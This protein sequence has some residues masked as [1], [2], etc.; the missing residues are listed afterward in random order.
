MRCVNTSV[1]GSFRDPSGFLFFR[2]GNLYRQINNFYKDHYTFLNTSGLYHTLIQKKLLIP[3]S[4]VDLPP[5]KPDIAFKIIQPTRIPFISYPYEWCFSQLKQAA[6][7]TL[8]IQKISLD[9][10]MILKDAS[11]YNI[12]FFEGKPIFIDTLSFERYEPGKPWIAYRQFCKHFIAPLA[13]M[14]YKDIRLGELLRSNID[15]IPLDFASSLLP[16]TTW[17]NIGI[18]MHLHLHAKSESKYSGVHKPL[19]IRDISKHALLGVLDN[20]TTTI[21]KMQWQPKGTEWI[22]Y[23]H[24]TNYT[25][26]AFEHKKQLVA[27]YLDYIKPES[28]WDLGANNGFFSRIAS[29]KGVFTLAFDMDPACVELN[30][31]EISIKNEPNVLPLLLD[32]TNPSPGIGWQNEERNSL[33]NRGPAD[34]VLALAL[35]HHL[36]IRTN[37]PLDRIAEFFSRICKSLV[38]E[39][40]PKKDSQVNKLLMNRKDIFNEYTEEDFKQK[41]SIYFHIVRKER[42]VSS[43]RT[44]YLMICR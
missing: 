19:E 17:L 4:E 26:D 8:E 43:E 1:T 36:A 18:L 3:H 42:I 28:V 2:Q 38:I 14:C 44:I 32:L 20:L 5:E 21:E 41:F 23:Y 25:R 7:L 12:Q 29:Q 31:R 13:L 39:F 15:G 6:L 16:K 30:Y 9:H 27:E 24:D 37:V 33:I 35:I 11:A 22:G 10:D 40:V 34:T